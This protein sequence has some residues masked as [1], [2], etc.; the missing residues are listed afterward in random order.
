MTAMAM[1]APLLKPPPVL[2]LL[3]GLSA[4]CD[5]PAE[6]DD[7]VLVCSVTEGVYVTTGC[8]DVIVVTMGPCVDGLEYVTT[9]VT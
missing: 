4:D 2:D 7:D 8:V 3:A 9:D 5:E 1:V 6:E